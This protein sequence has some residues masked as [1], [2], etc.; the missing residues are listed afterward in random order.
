MALGLNAKSWRWPPNRRGADFVL[1]GAFRQV[2]LPERATTILNRV[3]LALRLDDIFLPGLPARPCPTLT[4]THLPLTEAFI[5]KASELG[6]RLALL[7]DSSLVLTRDVV[8]PV[9][10][11]AHAER[12]ISLEL[13]QSLP[14]HARGLAW[15]H[16]RLS[17][18]DNKSIYRA[19][20]TR[21]SL[22][23]DAIGTLR[24]QGV[25]V[26]T[27]AP[28]ADP[29]TLL[30][31]ISPS[32]TASWQFW[33]A[34]SALSVACISMMTAITL[35]IRNSE[36]EAVAALRRQSVAELETRL[37]SLRAESEA[38]DTRNQDIAKTVDRFYLESGRLGVLTDLSNLLPDNS[39]IS[40]LTIAERR[41]TLAG[42]TSGNVADM[43]A[44]IQGA[45]WAG[46]V[47]LEGA[48]SFD[49]YS[50]QNRFVL[51]VEL[52]RGADAP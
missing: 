4:V 49:S 44:S 18:G 35:E 14:N 17:S 27:V 15:S 21:H 1:L 19:Y 5:K 46:T 37:T 7:L 16:R 42:F 30:Q 39:W 29:T 41:A 3:A 38:D 34:L 22:V 8:L 12:A 48:V 26:E 31:Q 47:S 9:A 6:P 40:E 36:A 51:V 50:N 20:I 2:P 24:R 45:S 32:R 52:V 11:A 43:I 25:H 10:A 28:V 33:A 23:E 13:R